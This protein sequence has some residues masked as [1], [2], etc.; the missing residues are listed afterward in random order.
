LML[1]L[2]GYFLGWCMGIPKLELFSILQLISSLSDPY[3][4]KL[5]SYK[6]KYKSI[7]N[8]SVSIT[9]NQPFF[10]SG[11]NLKTT[12]YKAYTTVSTFPK[13]PWSKELKK[14]AIKRQH[15]YWQKSVKTEQLTKVEFLRGFLLLKSKSVQLMKVWI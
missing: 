11:F 4:W 2:L 6:T 13:V 5:P 15:K 10:A 9:Y 12:T 8:I 1:V 7:S 14:K 3:T